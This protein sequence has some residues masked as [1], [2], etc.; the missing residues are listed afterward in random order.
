M[1]P[2][3]LDSLTVSEDLVSDVDRF[4]A[5]MDEVLDV[6]FSRGDESGGTTGG[7]DSSW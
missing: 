7:L 3:S 6:G 1:S 4:V 5:V 2:N